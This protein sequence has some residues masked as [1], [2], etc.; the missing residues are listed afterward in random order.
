MQKLDTLRR[1]EVTTSNQEI[2]SVTISGGVAEFPKYGHNVQTLYRAAD[3][4]LYQSKAAGHD[5][6]FLSARN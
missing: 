5:Q 2:F 4:A 3:A 1:L 6:I